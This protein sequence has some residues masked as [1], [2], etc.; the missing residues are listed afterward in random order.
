[1]EPQRTDSKWKVNRQGC[2]DRV[3][4]VCLTHMQKWPSLIKRKQWRKE[5]GECDLEGIAFD[6]KTGHPDDCS[7][8][9]LVK[10]GWD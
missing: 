5:T 6:V 4:L 9:S 8:R 10:R 3:T 7:D 2:E 1:M